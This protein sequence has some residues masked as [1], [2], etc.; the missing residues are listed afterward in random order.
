MIDLA[1][2]RRVRTVTAPFVVGVRPE[3]VVRAVVGAGDQPVEVGWSRRGGG[4]SELPWSCHSSAVIRAMACSGI[5]TQPG[6]LR[7]S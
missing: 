5:A 2:G 4:L 6:R 3:H 1:S 7:A